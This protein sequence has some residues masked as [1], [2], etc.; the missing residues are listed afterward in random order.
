MPRRSTS[1]WYM[2]PGVAWSVGFGP[3]R[4]PPA[5]AELVQQPMVELLPHAGTL[6]VAQLPPAG[7]RAAAAK[8]ADRR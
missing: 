3:V 2:D 1:S 6:P 5:W 7:D 4:S 8:L